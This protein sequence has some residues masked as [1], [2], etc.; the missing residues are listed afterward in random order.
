MFRILIL[1]AVIASLPLASTR[2]ASL[3]TYALSLKD[4]T[5]TPAALAVP[6]GQRFRI[7][8]TN[9]N[10]TAAEFESYDMKFEKIVVPAGSA[11]VFAGPLRAGTYKVFDDYQPDAAGIVTAK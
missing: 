4:K 7:T 9:V 6:A 3:P 2:A 8:L 5:F 1:A 11:T 10:A